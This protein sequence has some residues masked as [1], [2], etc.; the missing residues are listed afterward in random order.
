MDPDQHQPLAPSPGADAPLYPPLILASVS[1]QRVA[2]LNQLGAAP[3][4]LIPAEIN[5]APEVREKPRI[6]AERMARD[7][8]R[9]VALNN[10]GAFV[11]AADTVVAVGQRILP[12]A[13]D[14]A[15]ARACFKLLSGRSHQVLG[16]ICL[17][18]PDGRTRFRLVTTRVTFARIDA[19]ALDAYLTSDEW[20]G[21]AGGYAIQGM[22][23]G[24]VRRLAGSYSNVVGLSLHETH[25][26][27]KGNGYHPDGGWFSKLTLD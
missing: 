2:L 27:L 14:M 21:K 25:N 7:K 26:L 10:P 24:F 23:E 8:A 19:P 22:A 17:S 18:R 6:Y 12:K 5:E 13:E 16:A 4:F 3:D 15:Q 11:L 20:L 9:A 1:S